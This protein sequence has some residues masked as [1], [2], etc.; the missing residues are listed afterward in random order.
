VLVLVLVWV[1]VRVHGGSRKTDRPRKLAHRRKRKRKRKQ[2]FDKSREYCLIDRTGFHI[3][4]FGRGDFLSAGKLSAESIRAYLVAVESATASFPSVHA[5]SSWMASRARAIPFIR[6]SG[7]PEIEDDWLL[8]HHAT[9]PRRPNLT[10]FF[11]KRGQG[12]GSEQFIGS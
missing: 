2:K 11:Q 6:R 8:I 12:K 1:R 7:D 9:D 10:S 4:N 5:R 3:W